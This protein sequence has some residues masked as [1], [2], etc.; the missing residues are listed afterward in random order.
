[1]KRCE[2][3]SWLHLIWLHLLYERSEELILVKS[4]RAV[5]AYASQLASQRPERY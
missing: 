2:V 4:D 1:M 3:A 5:D